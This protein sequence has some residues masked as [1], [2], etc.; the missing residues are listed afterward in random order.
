M[1]CLS[2]IEKRRISHTQSGFSSK[3][4]MFGV[5]FKP[6]KLPAQNYCSERMRQAIGFWDII[7]GEVYRGNRQG[8]LSWEERHGGCY[9]FM[10][11]VYLLNQEASKGLIGWVW[12][13]GILPWLYDP[14][15]SWFS[16]IWKIRISH[17]TSPFSTKER[18]FGV[19]IEWR[20]IRALTQAQTE[21]GSTRFISRNCQ[22]HLVWK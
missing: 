5:A 20:N 17:A 12:E 18:T 15:M 8:L 6:S 13:M 1:C 9:T 22:G 2:L 14:A 21:R 4:N 16:L 7:T 3:E 19:P 10:V 11:L